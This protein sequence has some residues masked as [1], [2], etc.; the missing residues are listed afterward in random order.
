MSP[1]GFAVGTV[2]LFVGAVIVGYH[3]NS[4]WG[5]AGLVL[6]TAGLLTIHHV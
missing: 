2:L 1:I 6:Y 4:L 5:V 3:F